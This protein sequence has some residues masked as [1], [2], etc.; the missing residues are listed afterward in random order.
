MGKITTMVP[1]LLSQVVSQ[2]QPTP[3]QMPI[4]PME[5]MYI[6]TFGFN[7]FPKYGF[8]SYMDYNTARTTGT[9]MNQNISDLEDYLGTLDSAR[10][11]NLPGVTKDLS[12][13]DISRLQEEY[14]KKMAST[15]NALN[16][17][18]TASTP[19]T[20]PDYR[21][22]ALS[23]MLSRYNVGS[24]SDI[25][26]FNYLI[27]EYK[28]KH[29]L[30][31][32]T[33]ET[34]DPLLAVDRRAQQLENAAARTSVNMQG[35]RP[36]AMNGGRIGY[37]IGGTINPFALTQRPDD[38]G[39]PGFDDD[40][41]SKDRELTLE[42]AMARGVI[43]Y[44]P[45]AG[46]QV[47]PLTGGR[48]GTGID[49]NFVARRAMQA[50]QNAAA[51]T[52]PVNV[53]SR[54]VSSNFLS[55]NQS[56]KQDLL[57]RQGSVQTGGTPRSASERLSEINPIFAINRLIQAEKDAA[58]RTSVN[59]QGYR[60]GAMDGG[61]IS[62]RIGY[63]NGDMVSPTDSDEEGIGGVIYQ[64][65]DGNIISKKEAMKLF[66]KQAEE[67]EKEKKNKKAYGGIINLMGGGMPSMEMDYRG[68]GFIPVGA[69]ERADDVPARLSKNEFVMTAN[70]VRAAGGGSV[71]EGARRMYQ[72]MDA[73]EGRKR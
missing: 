18:V 36:G 25:K 61:I 24:L 13:E 57:M 62:T 60:P 70:A 9:P 46:F 5:A 55:P 68:G 12:T 11:I 33:F 53:I 1:N 59:M 23:E 10:E 50:E 42:E 72:L 34:R 19:T 56:M 73:L 38:L 44:D 40:N 58:A 65:E 3:Q 17:T 64:D 31:V 2:T 43:F 30:N 20:K 32:R 54:G 51:R 7:P 6:N 29:N 41:L 4:D 48:M 22:Q 66:K 67:E 14:V 52:S 71:D 37:Q 28:D 16:P 8:N 15:S 35:Y 63:K 26:N 21:Q 49:P 45:I 39:L 27:P 69:K 47:N